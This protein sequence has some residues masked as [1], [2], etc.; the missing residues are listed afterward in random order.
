[1]RD[2][3]G[4]ADNAIQPVAL[5]YRVGFSGN[6]TNV[7]EAFVADATTGP[8][9]ATLETWVSVVLPP[10]AGIQVVVQLRIITSNASGNDEWVAVDDILIANAVTSPTG[11]GGADPSTVEP[12]GVTRLLVAATPGTYPQS[13]S[14]TVSCDL[15]SIGGPSSQSLYDDGTHGDAAAGD[16]VFNYEALV[17]E[18]TAPGSKSLAV[19]VA[20]A[21]GRSS[22]AEIA[23]TVLETVGV[24]GGKPPAGLALHPSF[25]NPFRSATSIAFE[26]PE[27]TRSTW[28]CST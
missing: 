22:G 15:S 16:A 10:E 28:R 24:S 14:I 23:L 27:P 7:S 1:L 13:T 3:D 11:T 4:S 2:V 8:S 5:Q 18:G 17:A 19:V 20:D 9:L 6:F 21:E 26:I 25:P 12:G